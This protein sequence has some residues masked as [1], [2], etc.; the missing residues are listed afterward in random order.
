MELSTKPRRYILEKVT[1]Y[2]SRSCGGDCTYHRYAAAK[3]SGDR[4]AKAVGKGWKPVVHENL[5][6]FFRAV[7]TATGATMHQW[8][9]TKYWAQ[10]IVGGKQ[11]CV[12]GHSPEECASALRTALAR[13]IIALTEARELLT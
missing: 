5:G 10:I 8:S 11:T 3:V 13:Q 1:R 7:H 12:E 6:W 2:C 4:L 9:P